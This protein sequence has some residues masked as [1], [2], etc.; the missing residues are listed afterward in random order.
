LTIKKNQRL[1][2]VVVRS[3]LTGEQWPMLLGWQPS[4]AQ[5]QSVRVKQ[6]DTAEF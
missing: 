1:L 4:N 2:G 6:V 5:V 3:R